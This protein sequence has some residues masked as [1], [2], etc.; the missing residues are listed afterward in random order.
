VK[1]PT[2]EELLG[3]VRQIA[4]FVRDGDEVPET[5]ECD[6][7]TMSMVDDMDGTYEMSIDDA[8][9]TAGLCISLCRDVLGT[10]GS[11][12]KVVRAGSE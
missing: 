11:D 3:V 12:L 4:S 7:T 9:E 1:E 2:Y 5:F 6:G 8:F 10:D